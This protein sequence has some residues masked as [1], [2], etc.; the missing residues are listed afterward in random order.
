MGCCIPALLI[1]TGITM[2]I[3]GIMQ[4]VMHLTA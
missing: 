2:A 1:L 4:V 3:L